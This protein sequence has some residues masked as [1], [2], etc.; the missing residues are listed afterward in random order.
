[1][2]EF[3]YWPRNT[4]T[5]RLEQTAKKMSAKNRGLLAPKINSVASRTRRQ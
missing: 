4:K 2:K 5:N 3:I 1:M